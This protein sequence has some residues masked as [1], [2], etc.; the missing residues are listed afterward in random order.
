MKRFGIVGAVGAALFA[1][2]FL[3]AAAREADLSQAVLLVASDSLDGSPFEQ[4]VLVAAPLPDGGHIGFIVNRPTTV[5]LERLFPEDAA[6]RNVNEPVY[7]G[8]SALLSTVFA[9]TRSAPASG[10]T[11]IA[12]MPGV[13]AVLDGAT[14]DRIIETT[15]NAA[16]YFVGLMLWDPDELEEEI[17]KR[18]WEVRSPDADTVLP[19]RS[20]AHGATP[21]SP[22]TDDA[23]H[24][25][26]AARSR[27]A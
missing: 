24:G 6:A 10:G 23:S 16:R 20:Q 17:R 19:A 25:D 9:L 18:L 2:F 14:V 8:G 26:I 27:A 22:A 7:L 15:P 1:A 3:I 12:L 11:S 21:A 5:K 13:V 4:T